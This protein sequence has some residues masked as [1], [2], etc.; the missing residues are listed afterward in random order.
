[1]LKF[2][3]QI[4]DEIT[5]T[6]QSGS[7]D[8]DPMRCTCVN[9]K[10]KTGLSPLIIACERNLPSVAELLLQYGADI[11]VQDPKGRNP[12]AIAAFCGCNDTVEFLLLQ[13]R[14]KK[15]LLNQKDLNGCT[16][17]W[18]AA[19]TGNLSILKLLIDAGADAMVKDDEGLSP[20]D[21]AAKFKKE[22]V[23]EYFSQHA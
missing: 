22:K 18:L 11:C 4:D 5:P 15:E 14:T 12:L 2:L 3:L 1:M 9:R 8:D 23:E 10:N 13:T 6:G 20:Q 16:P 19:R 21:V 17:V 7:D